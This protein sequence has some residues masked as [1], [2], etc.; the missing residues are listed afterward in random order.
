L[1]ISFLVAGSSDDSVGVD[2]ER[3]I[4]LTLQPETT[5]H[6][7][8]I[9]VSSPLTED[10]VEWEGPTV[11]GADQTFTTQAPKSTGLGDL[12]SSGSFSGGSGNFAPQ[13]P[14]VVKPK[15]PA[16]VKAAK[17]ARAL[18]LCKKDHK[19]SKRAKCEKEA[20]KKYGPLKTKRKRK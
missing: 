8:V 2:L 3:E 10:T 11:Y 19:K 5:Y 18:R 16:Q 7:R 1:P 4:G 12:L 13:S 9:A 15:T 6:Y 20:R 17:L 14:T